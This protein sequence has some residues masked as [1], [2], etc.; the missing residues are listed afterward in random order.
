DAE[1]M[2][3][4]SDPDLVI[5]TDWGTDGNEFHGLEGLAGAIAEMAAA[6]DPWHQEIERLIDAGGGAVV[7]FMRLTA[8]G[9]ESGVP[10]DFGWALVITVR[11]GRIAAAQA[12]VDRDQA[13]A[14]AGVAE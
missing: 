2:R 13:L 14:A 4:V 6:W 9:R 11:G 3:E 8:Q 12:F 5:K 7:A 10:V 1:T